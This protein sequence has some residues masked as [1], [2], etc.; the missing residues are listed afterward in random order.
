LASAALCAWPLQVAAQSEGGFA[1]EEA[2]ETE[3]IVI[4]TSSAELGMGWLSEDSFKFGEYTGLTDKGPFAIANIDFLWRAPYDGDSTEYWEFSGA[5]LGLDSRSVH[6][7]AGQQGRFS[8]F[9]DYSEIPHFAAD[10]AATPYIGAG[11]TNLTLPP[12][13]TDDTA[14]PPDP[15]WDSSDN[16]PTQS[17]AKMT[18]LD[19]VLNPVKLKTERTKA[20]AGFTFDLD[21][22]WS[23]G[24]SFSQ[25]RKDGLESLAGIFGAS[26]GNP[27][28][29]ILPKPIDYETQD[30]N[31]FLA[32]NGDNLQAQLSYHLSQFDNDAS[33]LTF[34]NAYEGV[35]GWDTDQGF[36]Q[37]GFGRIALE[38]DNTAHSVSLSMGYTPD[39]TTRIAGNFSYT[40]MLQDEDFLPYSTTGFG[41]D[42]I[43][44]GA[45]PRDSLE[46]DITK[47]HGALS[48]AKQITPDLDL[49]AQ[50]TYDDRD[51]NTPTDI[52]CYVPNDSLDQDVVCG[53]APDDDT[54]SAR[55][56]INRPYSRTE[57]D[58]KLDATYRVMPSTKVALGYAFETINRD[59]T[60]VENT[61]ENTGSVKVMSRP[62]SFASGWLKYAFSDRSGSDYIGNEP[63]LVSHTPGTVEAEGGED[64]FWEANPFL[65][66]YYIADRRR[67]RV[68]GSLNLIATDEINFGLSG[69]IDRSDY[70][71]TEIG[72]TDRNYASATLDAAFTP[73][74][75]ISLYGFFTYDRMRNQQIGYERNAAL[76]PGDP[77]DPA[78]LWGVDTHDHGYTAG[79]GSDW[80]VIKDTLKLGIDYTFSHTKTHYEFSGDPALGAE[81][82]PDVTSNLHSVGARAEYTFAEGAT[83][84][85]FY[86]YEVFNN[87]DFANE[88]GSS[89]PFVITL[90]SQDLDYSEHLIG[91]SVRY[92]F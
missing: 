55:A 52:F 17:P 18:Q 5:N 65:R 60:E 57:H 34:Q 71:N 68:S 45:L 69:S 58:V 2:P 89:L 41:V 54:V 38:P 66:K 48:A 27:R 37:G 30:A 79:V 83:A 11:G 72:L 81:P 6:I 44:F 39:P 53:D 62:L 42:G 8:V 78:R 92:Q 90:G 51:N 64:E 43:A 25:E 80:T 88:T 46:G 29:A 4:T 85:L 73:N 32:Y 3:P 19:N 7:E 86:R 20:G 74:E 24:G 84:S 13:C 15:C 47:I 70:H 21:Q 59:L 14:P 10:D 76:L 1:L 33:T 31:V 26:G 23:L 40:R 49:S 91:V 82:V 75:D 12:G 61:Y 36:T 50:Y 56:R 77:L 35:G 16:T 87:N 28:S 22:D 63:V 9:L 67:H